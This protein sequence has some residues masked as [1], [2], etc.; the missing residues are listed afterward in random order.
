MKTFVEDP[1]ESEKGFKPKLSFVLPLFRHN[2]C[3]R[4]QKHVN[5]QKFL[6]KIFFWKIIFRK[7]FHYEF[8]FTNY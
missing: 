7:H 1:L 3:T 4:N 2:K 6:E 8:S 5:F